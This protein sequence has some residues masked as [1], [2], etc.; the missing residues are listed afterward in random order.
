MNII[1]LSEKGGRQI[2]ALLFSVGLLQIAGY[3]LSGALVCSDGGF[4]IPQPDSPLYYQAARRIVEG[5]PFSYSDSSAVCAGTTTILYPFL[6]AIPYALGFTG[7]AIAPAGFVINSI[8]YLLFLL[9][10]YK[11]ID[12]WCGRDKAK[13][14]ASLTIALS[15][16]CAFATF[17]QTDIG[18]WLAFSGLFAATLSMK[19][20]GFAGTLLVLA[21]W[22]R[23]E[24]MI[25]VVAF[26]VMTAAL[27]MLGVDANEEFRR[28]VV[29]SLLGLVSMCGVFLL[30][31]LLTGNVQFSSVAG[32]GHFA[33]LPFEQAVISSISDL[34]SIVKGVVLG[35]TPSSTRNLISVPLLGAVLG[36]IGLACYRWKR[37][38]VFGVS[39]ILLAAVGGIM[40]V[41]ISGLQG[42]NMDRYLVWTMPFGSV[43]IANGVIVVEDRMPRCMRCLPSVVVIVF[44]LIGAIGAQFFFCQACSYV[45]STRLFAKD[46]ETLM[47]KGASVGGIPCGLAYF[48]SDRRLANMSGI[49]SPE[50]A[51]Q[52]IPENIER[53]RNVSELRFDYWLVCSDLVSIIG[54]P[55]AERLGEVLLPG[56]SGMTL[57]KADWS[58]FN[59]NGAKSVDDKECVARVDVGYAVD[60]ADASYNVFARWGYP[61]FDRIVQFGK[62]GDKEVIDVGRVVLGGDEMTVP[63]K[64]GEDVIVVMRTWPRHSLIRSSSLVNETIDCVFSNPLRF[65]IA[66]DGK[67]VDTPEISYSTNGFS[68][69]SFKIPGS[70]IHN[71][72]SRIG[73]LG[74]H[75]TFG[76]WF[77]Q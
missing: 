12:N 72:L 4:A 60:E 11:A 50:F 61:L 33:T 77:Y 8:F 5:C 6:L 36:A 18:F 39:V 2:V 66:V 65:N 9:G 16:H 76:Y 55:A 48:F 20:I 19:R 58:M 32:K 30:N 71:T 13:L 41:S 38:D 44:A 29:F 37:E 53:L 22:V 7:D 35:V 24:G 54:R 17:S 56:P 1:R 14:V 40:N 25:L 59:S 10:W 70:S 3:Y 64:P 51:P 27:H 23:P 74:D 28:R 62:L 73:F 68:D 75:I 57:M 49:Y 42:A 43:L 21:A 63:L 52:D 69:V 26:V 46:C 47:P 34:Y 67:V 15:G 45:D 31:Y